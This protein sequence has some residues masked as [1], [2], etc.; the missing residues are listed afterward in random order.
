M[1]LN[2]N[3][4]LKNLPI[5]LKI[6]YGFL[7][8]CCPLAA[9]SGIVYDNHARKVVVDSV[10]NQA[11]LVCDQVEYKFNIHYSAPIER[12][13]YILA[14]SPQ[15]QN[16]LMSSK[17]EIAIYR[18][19]VERLFLSLSKGCRI[20]VSTTFLDRSGQEKIGVYGNKRKRT[21]RSLAEIA[22]DGPLGQNM[23]KLFM[24][25]KSNRAQIL[26]HTE[27][28]YDAQNNL[29]ILVGITIQEPEAGG[30]GGAI[31]QHCDLTDFIHEVSQNK[32]LDTAVM[33]VYESDWKNLL[34]PP[35]D[36][37]QQDPKL[38][39]ARGKKHAGSHI[40]IA[41]CKLFA[42]EKPVMTVVCSIPH[43]VISKELIPIIWSVITIFSA[44]MAASLTISFLISRWISRPIQNLARVAK[45]VS[46]KKDYSAR[47]LVKSNDEMGY[48]TKVFNTM[49][50]QIQKRDSALVEAK[51][52]LEIKV[53]ERTAD[54]TI[55]NKHLTKEIAERVKA[56]AELKAAQE[57]LIDTARQTGMAETATD[58]L[59]NVGNVLNSVS[60]TTASIRKRVRDSK[61]SYLTEVVG[62]LEEHADDLS[63]FMTTEERGRKLPA[64]L[65]N[66]SQELITEQ[67]RY[68]E[69]LETLT[70]H[71]EHMA[72]I[73][74]LQQS[75]SKTTGMVEPAS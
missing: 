46:V 9:I 64:F 62:L 72:E 69:A 13:L 12:E 70:K 32:V 40:Y 8:V 36:E 20:D 75:Y 41:K 25:L 63:T 18:A 28:F 14:S 42:R 15:L 68:L 1:N 65:A 35:D 71:V 61:V 67:E 39:L 27:L 57:K 23:K 38:R 66:L 44:L 22:Q 24:E 43:E 30:F 4:K 73:I 34:S 50:E 3:K 21:F 5:F 11:S 53:R 59:H 10:R 55:T 45:E 19:E 54:L 74:R 6:L 16:Y 29:G 7:S 2:I 17:E 31:I 56:E 33:W 51:G 47:A 48:L 26:N 60:V 52:Q 37:I 58:V 49:L